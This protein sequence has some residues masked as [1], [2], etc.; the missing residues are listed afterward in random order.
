M[1]WMHDGSNVGVTM[2][3]IGAEMAGDELIKEPRRPPEAKI[4]GEVL[5]R[6]GT[7]EGLHEVRVREVAGGKYRVNVYVRAGIGTYRVAHSFFVEADA[8]GAV[9]DSSPTITRQY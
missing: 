8:S 5:S 9:L 6:L 2:S 3:T 4:V 1:K 7:P